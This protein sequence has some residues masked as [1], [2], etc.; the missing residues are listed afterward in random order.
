MNRWLGDSIG[1]LDDDT[2]VVETSNFHPESS[3]RG[4]S[5]NLH[6]VERFTMQADGNLLYGF[7]VEDDTVWTAPWTGEYIWR[8]SDDRVYEYACH[9]GNYAMGNVLR[10]ARLL[11]KEAL[12]A[13]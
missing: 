3:I 9:E 5:E 13:K 4:G 12:A 11:E 1:W 6:V 2:L 8:A 7:T 10:G